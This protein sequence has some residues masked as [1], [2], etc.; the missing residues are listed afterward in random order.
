MVSLLVSCDW[1]LFHLLPV[2]GECWCP[3]VR[4]ILGWD[5]ATWTVAGI[6][7]RGACS[8]RTGSR[9]SVLCRVMSCHDVFFSKPDHLTFSSFFYQ[10]E[11][12]IHKRRFAHACI[13]EG[14]TVHYWLKNE[15]AAKISKPLQ[16]QLANSSKLWIKQLRFITPRASS[17]NKIRTRWI[18]R[19]P[20]KKEK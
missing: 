3:F 12:C 20:N 10:L 1:I 11:R 2:L 7:Q 14:T 5:I 6:L 18:S 15:W 19:W 16:S 17:M 4:P 13:V 8:Y 9:L